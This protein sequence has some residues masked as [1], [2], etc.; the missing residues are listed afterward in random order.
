MNDWEEYKIVDLCS[1]I[2]SGGTPSTRKQEYYGGNIPWLRTQEIN[3]NR[4]RDTELFITD[5]GLNESSA[6]WI[7]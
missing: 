7:P 4:I 2:T 5:K 1:K 6:K 3:F